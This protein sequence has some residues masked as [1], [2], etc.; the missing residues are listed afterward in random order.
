M[1]WTAEQIAE[2][3][4]TPLSVDAIAQHWPLI[5]DALHAVGQASERSLAAAIATV[6]IE[7]ASTFAPVRE[8]FWLWTADEAWHR[9]NLTRY[10]PYYGRGYIQLT[11]DYNYKHYGNLIGVDILGEPD[12]ALEPDIAAKVFAAYWKGRDIQEPADREDWREVRK[13]VQGGDAGLDRLVKIAT[14]L[15]SIPAKEQ[16]PMTAIEDRAAQ[17]GAQLGNGG[18]PLGP[19]RSL[20]G[21]R[22]RAYQNALLV[23]LPGV[24]VYALPEASVLGQFSPNR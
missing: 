2:A 24:G 19:E 6:A 4:G 9:R 15:L 13:R 10:Y 18:E 22:I 14:Q 1:R 17:L 3:C 8:A 23:Y 21:V 5:E 16:E 12:R 7:T 20:S 11:W